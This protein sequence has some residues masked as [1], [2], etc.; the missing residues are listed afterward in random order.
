MPRILS[1]DKMLQ[2]LRGALAQETAQ[3]GFIQGFQQGKTDAAV[4]EASALKDATRD[5]AQGTAAGKSAYDA[6]NAA[7]PKKSPQPLPTNYDEMSQAYFKTL[8]DMDRAE[9]PQARPE[10]AALDEAHGS[11]TIPGAAPPLQGAPPPPGGYGAPPPG[12]TPQG[13]PPGVGGLTPE[14]LA[15]LDAAARNPNAAVPVGR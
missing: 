12:T 7:G 2:D 4:A 15:M 1:L 13:P 6:A 5:A 8:A 14:Q 10:L 11:P 3:K 9:Q